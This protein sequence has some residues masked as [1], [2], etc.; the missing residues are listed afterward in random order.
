MNILS[1]SHAYVGSGHNGGAET[2]LHDVMRLLR[3]DKHQC[4]AL[5]SKPH[6]DGS[7]SYVMDGVKVQAHA[8]K[9]DPDLYFPHYDL[10]ISHLE[11]AARSGLISKKY[12]KKAIHLLHNDQEYCIDAA[13]RYADGLIFN[14]EWIRPA[15]D[16]NLPGVVLHP[17]VDPKRYTIETT[18]EFITL[19]NLTIGTTDRISYD[20]G[21]LTFYEL[22]RRFP[23]E[24]FLG[25]KGGYGDQYVPDDLP[26]NVTI[27]EHTNNILDVYRR[28]KVVLVPSRYESYGRVA[29]EA[30]CSGIPGV[31]SATEG[32]REAMG[33]SSAFCDYGAFDQW[34]AALSSVL[35]NYDHYSDLAVKRAAF[36]WTR[37]LS[38]WFKVQSFLMNLYLSKD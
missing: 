11:C 12:G 35:E 32:T 28:S 7:G 17:P 4:T 34:E 14:T 10:V 36:N 31:L 8:N 3:W 1:Y 24:Q 22:A 19:V 9:M 15:Y 13:E 21:G 30:G 16:L 37:T 20:K 38:E 18:R 25:V 33:F 23:N 2:T 6:P 29:V 5:L 26:P 27:W